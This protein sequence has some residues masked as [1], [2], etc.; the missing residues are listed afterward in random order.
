LNWI[1]FAAI[2]AVFGP[3]ASIA[4]GAFVYGKLTQAVTDNK[5][6]TEE[7]G[8]ILVKHAERLGDHE[9]KIGKI[10]EWKA[11]IKIGAR[12]PQ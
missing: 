2:A 8:G 11:G 10:E 3:I 9:V 4:V 12:I 7:H 6:K 5:A 1:A